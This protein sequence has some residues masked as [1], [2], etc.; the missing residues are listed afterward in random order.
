M[1]IFIMSAG[2]TSE[3]HYSVMS[4][5][6]LELCGQMDYQIMMI[7]PSDSRKT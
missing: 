5:V 6:Y 4:D 7:R 3:E 1:Y 2:Q